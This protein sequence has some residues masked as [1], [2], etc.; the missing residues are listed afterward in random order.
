M[1]KLWKLRDCFR[2][3]CYF[4]MC[5][6]AEQNEEYSPKDQYGVLLGNGLWSISAELLRSKLTFL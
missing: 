3:F 6:T 4:V 1:I 5:H 2:Y